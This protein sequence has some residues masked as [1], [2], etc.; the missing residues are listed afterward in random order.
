MA[1]SPN[2]CLIYIYIIYV[3]IYILFVPSF[4]DHTCLGPASYDNFKI[5]AATPDHVSLGILE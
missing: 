4:S 1:L 2:W 3:C 5:L